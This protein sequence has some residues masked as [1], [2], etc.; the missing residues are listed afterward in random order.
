MQ[1]LELVEFL[2]NPELIPDLRELFRYNLLNFGRHPGNVKGDVVSNAYITRALEPI[3][4]RYSEHFKV[5]VVTGPRQVGKTTM[6]RHLAAAEEKQTGVE[7][8]YVT[9]DNDAIRMAAKSDPALFLQ[10]YRAPV[11]IDEIQKA[12]E[13]L[14]YIKMAVDESDATGN[15]WLTGSQPLHLMKEVS[16][17]LAGRAG[18][19]E[20]LGLSH[21]EL[22]STPSEPYAPS[23]DYF[24]RRVNL[25]TPITTTEVFEDIA[26]GGFPAI[27]ALPTDL[28]AGAYESYLETY[29]MRDI[30]DLAQVGDELRFRR[31]MAACAALTARPVVYAELARLADIDEKTAKTWLSLLASTYL[32]KILEPYANNLLKRLSKQPL[33]HFTDAGL[34]AY[35][36][37][38]ENARTMELGAMAGQLFETHVFGEL[39]KSFVNAG[40]RAPLRFFRN[41]DKKEIDLLLEQNGTLYPIEAKKSALPVARDA[42]NFHA[43]D[44]VAADVP[45]DLRA[46]RREIGQG[47]IICM[48]Q[49]AFPVSQS[50]WALPVWAI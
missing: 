7:R 16:E 29:I 15:Y 12:P 18:I 20:M 40:R 47:A 26:A 6:L 33:L 3:I 14:P 24:T 34:A 27:R 19:V 39:Y 37:G 48:A 9:L 25:A 11:L 46:F 13:L 17:S 23:P 44:P 1:S 43:L 35:L 5:V 30:R 32:V 2:S 42:K 45:K 36:C 22:T 49:D 31:F 41:N 8:A 4:L 21:A 50:A 28:R 38:W 10:R